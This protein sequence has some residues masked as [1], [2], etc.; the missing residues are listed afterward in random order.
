MKMTHFWGVAKNPVLFGAT[1]DYGT[2]IH[3]LAPVTGSEVDLQESIGGKT[4]SSFTP[5]SRNYWLERKDKLE[6]GKIET[7]WLAIFNISGSDS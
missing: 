6:V 5:L 3:L 2:G 1:S 7:R 4:G